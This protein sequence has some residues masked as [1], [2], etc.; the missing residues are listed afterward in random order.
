MDPNFVINLSDPTDLRSKYR[1]AIAIL[2]VKDR[3]AVRWQSVV[4]F[5]ESQLPP[6][7][8]PTGDEIATGVAEGEGNGQPEVGDNGQT[9]PIV[10][11]VV[12]IVNR[13]PRVIRAREVREELMRHGYDLTSDQVSN[14][15]HYAAHEA[16]KIKSMPG[17][18][19]Y[20]PFSYKETEPSDPESDLAQARVARVAP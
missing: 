2:K 14:A 15:L 20:A 12:E 7:E 11:L 6:K 17:R 1:Q 16:R 8:L 10:E 4:D 18:G 9:R 5:L 13:R 19:Y 3:E